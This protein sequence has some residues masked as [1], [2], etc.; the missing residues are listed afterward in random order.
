MNTIKQSP[1]GAAYEPTW[2]SLDARPTPPWFDDSKFGL[3]VHWGVYSVPAWA[4]KR[5]DVG[6][7]SEAY[8]EWFW[9][10]S[11]R[12]DA[13]CAKFQQRVYG[14]KFRYQDFAPQFKAELFDP[15]QWADLFARS[16]A[17]YV[18]LTGKHHDGFCLWPSQHAWNWNSVDIGPH[19][20]LVGDLSA[21][22]VA[23]G[24]RMAL[25]YSL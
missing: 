8:A 18:I 20:D 3:F 25:Y 22:V 1:E 5:K 19:R 17:R 11:K 6:S 16:G 4:P 9:D 2:A 10:L 24:L 23:K 15:N 7:P 21:S 14:D 13:P 12:K